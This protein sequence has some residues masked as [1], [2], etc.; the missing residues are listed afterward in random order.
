MRAILLAGLACVSSAAAAED[1]TINVETDD[2]NGVCLVAF[3]RD[4][5]AKLEISVRARDANLNL[6][7]QN[8]DADWLDEGE[9]LPISV[10]SDKGKEFT[11]PD[12]VYVAGFTYRV[13]G[14]GL[15]G[16]AALPLLSAL[17]GGKTLTAEFSDYR[18]TFE[19]QQATGTLFTDYAYKFMQRCMKDNGGSTSF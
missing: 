15:K 6:N 19:I 11:I 17:K 8:I 2:R 16:N 4:D 1:F 13:E 7:I 10:T 14:S 3:P 12:G 9:Y 18:A 5:G